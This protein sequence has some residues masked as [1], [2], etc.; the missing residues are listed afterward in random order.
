MKQLIYALAFSTLSIQVLAADPAPSVTVAPEWTR[1]VRTS[2]SNISIQ[3]C[4]E[5]PLRRGYPIHDALF[6]ALRDLNAPYARLHFW[7]PYPKMAVAEL[8]PPQ[9]GKTYWDFTLMDQ[10]TEDFMQATKG[11]PVLFDPGTVP[12]WMFTNQKL[13]SDTVDDA[14]AVDWSYAKDVK[15]TDSTVKLFAE[16]Q[17]RLASWYMKGGFRDEYGKWHASNH[18]YKIDF[19]EVLNEADGELTAAQYTKVYD[20]VVEEVRKV[21]PDMKFA[22][23]ALADIFRHADYFAYFLDPRNHRPG[24]PVDLLTYHFYSFPDSD[25]P[26]EVM[27]YTIFQQ[28]DK[29]L[30]A[31]QHIE[32][33]REKLSPLTR[34]AV[35]EL[36]SLLP[37]VYADRLIKPISS[38]YWN[39]AGAMLAYTY[40]NLAAM[41]IE[42]VHAAELIDFPGQFPATTLVDWNTGRPNARYWVVKM[43]RD[44]FGPGD[45]I[46]ERDSPYHDVENPGLGVQ[47]YSQGFITPSG[48]RRVL[49]V[50][51]RSRPLQVTL[52]DAAGGD[53]Q[54]VDQSTTSQPRKQ[55][56]TQQSLRLPAF[57]VA[58]VTL[59]RKTTQ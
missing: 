11:Q 17:A 15:P 41:G 45:H 14:D 29:F 18:R 5:P 8:K 59:P 46:V 57:A 23:P 7:F 24:I 25:E 28:A 9:E 12:R 55:P 58:V 2:R 54:M 6:D 39:L 13:R 50:N 35:D 40:G 3:V 21:V 38:A 4:A 53:L 43:L 10:I 44:N 42:M 56:L 52:P 47:L 16:Y 49:L 27:Q 1:I 19:W 26:D 22:G 34:T 31:A 30:G 20:A 48:D 37:G 32:A 36:G 51:K 33:V